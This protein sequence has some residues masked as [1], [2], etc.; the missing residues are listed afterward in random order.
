MAGRLSAAAARA[1]P[2][3]AVLLGWEI[4]G[5][6]LA[7]R[8]LP[9]LS[10]VLRVL[11]A[12]ALSGRLGHQLGATLLRVFWAFAIAM[13]LGTATGVAMGRS[14]RIDRLLDSLVTVLLN[15]PA[16]V[17]IVLIFVWFG[18]SEA[19]TIAAVALNKFPA[20]AVT[21]REGARAL[22]RRLLDMARS[23]HLAPDAT[24][25]HVALPQLTPYL[26]AAAR[27]G[28]AL[29]WKI[30]LVA[31]LLGRSDGVGFQIQLYFQL[32]DV[33]G[34]LA[35]TLAFMAVVQ[36]IEWGLLQPLERR[37]NRWR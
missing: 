17:G 3:L 24:W 37:L 21:L 36:A 8:L 22:D 7:T 27:A 6:L 5:Q 20:T 13:A 29:I 32:F 12:E 23:F 11:L 16:L 31:E 1:L 30:V 25:R 33:A 14:P 18:Q 4:A 9:P 10:A 2:I 28:F 35:Y 26:F 34:I 19:T 15:L